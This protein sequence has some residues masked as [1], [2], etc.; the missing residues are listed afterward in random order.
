MEYRRD[1][2]EDRLCLRQ[3]KLY[4][5]RDFDNHD[6]KNGIWTFD[7][8]TDDLSAPLSIH[9]GE[10]QARLVAYGTRMNTL[11]NGFRS[12]DLFDPRTE[13]FANGRLQYT[14]DSPKR[15]VALQGG[16]IVRVMAD[17]RFCIIMS[18]V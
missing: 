9:W 12:M 8:D 5:Y 3:G 2:G 13:Q 16:N 7:A 10:K 11:S 6:R 1:S 15:I 18:R 17:G 4:F 14:G